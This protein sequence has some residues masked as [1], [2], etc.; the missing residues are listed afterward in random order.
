MLQYKE[1]SDSP[2]KLGENK[3]LKKFNS[4]S[5]APFEVDFEKLHC[6]SII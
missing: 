6:I 1:S 5:L 2:D 4:I 3:P